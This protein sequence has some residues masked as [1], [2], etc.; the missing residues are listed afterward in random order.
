[1]SY[2]VKNLSLC[3]KFTW[4]KRFCDF[5]FR[6]RTLIRPYYRGAAGIVLVYD[7]TDEKTF[8]SIEDWMHSIDENTQECQII[9]KVLLANK[10]D[11]NVESHRVAMEDGRQL[12]SK[13]GVEFFQGDQIVV[14]Y[15]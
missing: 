8:S 9:Q 11:L 14:I 5:D 10:I 1:M 4:K 12:A 13:H 7:V 15:I 3:S 6:F 2:V